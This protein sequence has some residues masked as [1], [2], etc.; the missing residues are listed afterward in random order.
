MEINV[1]VIFNFKDI[2]KNKIIIYCKLIINVKLHI[3]SVETYQ[4]LLKRDLRRNLFILF[5]GW[6]GG[7]GR[8]LASTFMGTPIPSQ[9][10][11]NP[12]QSDEEELQF[13][14]LQ[15]MSAILCC[16]PCFEPQGLAE[17]GCLYPWLDLLLASKD[18]KVLCD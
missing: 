4:T 6:S 10:H 7:F 13:C 3:I 17:E 9:A 5:A 11:E 15:A 1:I 8:N 14:A 16:G 18:T 2:F 12:S